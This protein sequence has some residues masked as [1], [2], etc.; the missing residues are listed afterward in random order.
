MVV[1]AKENYYKI[2]LMNSAFKYP[3][4]TELLSSFASKVDWEESHV[5]SDEALLLEYLYSAPETR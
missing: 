4:P 2:A 5:T 1:E 3:I